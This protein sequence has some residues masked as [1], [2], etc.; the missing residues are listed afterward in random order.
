MEKPFRQ[1]GGGAKK[2]Q[3]EKHIAIFYGILLSK[4]RRHG[5][6]KWEPSADLA[7]DAKQIMEQQFSQ[8]EELQAQLGG[9]GV[10]RRH[11][12]KLFEKQYGLSPEEYLA[13][14]RLEKAK[15]LL[16]RGQTVTEVAFSVGFESHAA[17]SVFF[18]KHTGLSPRDYQAGLLKH[19]AR[20]RIETPL[21]PMWA[22]ADEEG[23][24]SLK[25]DG[26]AAD[27]TTCENPHLVLLQ[28]QLKDYFA[29]QRT[30]FTV[31]LSLRGTPFQMRVWQELRKIPYG[32]TRSYGEIAAA[33]GAPKAARAVGTAN[34]RNPVLILIPCHRVVGKDGKLV[35]YAGGL[36]RKQYLLELEGKHDR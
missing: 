32:E 17:F 25:F 33:L 23:I 16:A 28:Q 2:L 5:M 8:R 18:R 36:D 3:T 26:E 1:S 4:E 12:T 6:K 14:L 30:S 24:T 20:C 15:E 31:P 7:E 10:S 34:N 35:G 19:R 27:E 9:L 21:G 13:R 22:A 11:L 29:G